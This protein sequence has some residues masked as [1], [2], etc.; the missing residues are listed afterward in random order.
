MGW[1]GC[2]E[3]W[4]PTANEETVSRLQRTAREH[5][6]L[7][8]GG[9]DFHGMYNSRLTKLGE[10]L[11][12]DEQITELLNY[13]AKQRRLQKK[14]AISAEKAVLIPIFDGILCKLHLCERQEHDHEHI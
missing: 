13:K 2:V 8:T 11:T 4:H 10:C 1:A 7:M 12:P 14:A 6:L 9:S 5:H 3:V